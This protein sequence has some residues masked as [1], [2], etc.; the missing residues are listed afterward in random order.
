MQINRCLNCMAEMGDV[1]VCPH[2]GYDPSQSQE[3]PYSLRPGS[4]ITS[5][6]QGSKFS[7]VLNNGKYKDEYVF[8]LGLYP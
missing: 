4:M 8:D 1:T 6:T 7:Y 3:V 5:I 2:C